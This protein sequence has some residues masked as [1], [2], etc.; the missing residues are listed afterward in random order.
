MKLLR[1]VEG[2]TILPGQGFNSI[3][4]SQG[5]QAVEYNG[6]ESLAPVLDVDG[7]T[8]SFNLRRIESLQQMKDQLN[9]SASASVGVGVYSGDA[10]AKYI[11]SRSF[12]KYSVF[13]LI[14]VSVVAPSLV[15]KKSVMTK[16]ALE[17]AENGFDRFLGFCGDS[18]CYG[19]QIGGQLTAI[20]QFESKTIANQEKVNASVSAAISGF[21]GGRASFASAINKLS[22]I[23]TYSLTIFRKGLA[24]SIPRL[25]DLVEY[26]KNFPEEV[27]AGG[28]QVL[29]G[30]LRSY[31][32]AENFPSDLI[33]PS[34]LERMANTMNVICQ[35]LDRLYEAQGNLQF[36]STH[37]AQYKRSIELK[38]EIDH[39]FRRHESQINS[40]ID[41]AIN[42]KT[43]PLMD[44]PG[45]PEIIEILPG[46]LS[47]PEP[48]PVV[49]EVFDG[50]DYSGASRSFH[51]SIKNLRSVKFNDQISSFKINGKPGEY[52]VTFYAGSN[53][54]KGRLTTQSPLEVPR[55]GDYG[56]RLSPPLDKVRVGALFNNEIGSIKIEKM[57]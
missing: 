54:K 35:N 37:A 11:R 29:R 10:S 9:I 57:F 4:A 33:D 38:K 6:S 23:G 16:A 21:G 2:D 30:L 3:S 15:L 52:Q 50:S 25:E 24:V 27:A 40:L 7:F 36:L 41:A 43:E 31:E 32:T 28:S 12:N 22:S 48:L 53:F 26:S 5:G 42:L 47:S 49:V 14:D 19:L 8:T 1:I 39:A 46:E 45:P 55:I 51:K 18:Y 13:I 17:A 44:A 56:K 20:A 34:I